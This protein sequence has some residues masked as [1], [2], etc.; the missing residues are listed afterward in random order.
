MKSYDAIVIGA[1]FAGLYTLYRLRQQGLDVRVIEAGTDVGGTWYWNRYPGARCD[2]ESMEYSFQFDD[3]LQ[4]EW[5]WTERYAAQPEILAYINHVAD[6]YQLR[7][8]IQFETRVKSAEF[9]EQQGTWH[10]VTDCGDEYRANFVV[11]ATGCLSVPNEPEIPGKD[12]FAGETYHTGRWPHESVD[13]SGK[14]VGVIGTGSSAIQSVPCIAQQASE[15]YVFQRTPAYSVPAQNVPLDQD[16]QDRLKARYE[17]FRDQNR[18]ESFGFGAGHPMNQGHYLEMPD[19]ERQEQF[20][21]HWRLGGLLFL[22][23]FGDIALNR[24]A[25]DAA[26]EFVRGKIR[27]IVHDPETAEKLCPHTNIMGKRLCADSGYYETFNLPHVHLVDVKADPI[28]EITESGLRTGEDAFELDC[29]V[30]ATGF[31]AMTGALNRIDIRGRDGQSLREKWSDGPRTYLG[32]EVAGFPNLF[33]VTGPGSPSVLTNMLPSIEQNV[34]FITDCIAY[35]RERELRIIEAQQA[36]EDAWVAHVNAVADMTLFPDTDSWY[37]GANIAGKPRVFM[38]LIGFPDY[39][40][41]CDEVAANG[42]E[43]FALA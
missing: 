41:R 5:Q 4:Q 13:F 30:F 20:E 14:R 23:S 8:D 43:G 26:A 3:D 38:A 18:G 15:L 39:C 1:G 36:A 29:I 32:M 42:Y 21:R 16:L 22:R 33:I 17:V 2:I 12:R 6:R 24:E 28:K 27:E 10:V 40:A 19:E 37:C 31:D 34:N 35:M 25:N 11:A 9:D 7:D